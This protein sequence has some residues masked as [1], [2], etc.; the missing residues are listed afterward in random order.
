MNKDRISAFTLRIASSNGT[1]LITVLYDI[2]KEYENEA[3]EAFKNDEK[4]DAVVALKKCAEVISH[5]QQDLNFKYSVSRDLYSLYDF[6]QR[7]ISRSIY[8][9]N[10][11]GL[12]EAKQIMDKLGEAFE[13][14]SLEDDSKPLMRNAQRVSAG[15]TY[16]PN[17]LNEVVT[18]NSINRGFFA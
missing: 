6:C 5:L 16:G 10:D 3:L 17:S 15:Y 14:I 9:A 4:T 2:Y 1:E 7:A 12:L 18:S 8:K 11:E 13:E